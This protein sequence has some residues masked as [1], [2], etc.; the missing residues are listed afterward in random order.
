MLLACCNGLNRTDVEERLET[1]A[2]NDNDR[3]G[4]PRQPNPK[5][6]ALNRLVGTGALENL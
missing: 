6:H 1:M 3:A 5:L 4:K 2:K